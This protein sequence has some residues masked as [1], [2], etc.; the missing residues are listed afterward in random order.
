MAF[1]LRISIGSQTLPCL[2]I[3]HGGVHGV[4]PVVT[5]YEYGRQAD[6]LRVPTWRSFF[7]WKVPAGPKAP[8]TPKKGAKG[9][10]RVVATAAVATP[11]TAAGTAAVAVAA[12]VSS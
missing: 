1:L 2:L 9:G 6:W 7:M 11:A 5:C 4:C 8:R 12:A 3:L 10:K